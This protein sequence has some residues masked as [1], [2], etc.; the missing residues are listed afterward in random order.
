MNPSMYNTRITCDDNS[1]SASFFIHFT[2]YFTSTRGK[3]NP[4]IFSD[5]KCDTYHEN[6]MGQTNKVWKISKR[7]QRTSVWC[8]WQ[9]WSP[10]P[11]WWFVMGGGDDCG[12]GEWYSVY[13]WCLSNLINDVLNSLCLALNAKRHL[14]HKVTERLTVIDDYYAVQFK[15]ESYMRRTI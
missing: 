13:R 15:I 2:P 11:C 1:A 3:V 12:W 6:L 10:P 8:D 14:R 5:V 7:I 9:H 4:H